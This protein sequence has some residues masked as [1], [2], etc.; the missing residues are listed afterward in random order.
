MRRR[1][2]RTKKNQVTVSLISF[3]DLIGGMIGALSLIIIS[4]SLSQVVPQIPSVSHP[5]Y[6]IFSIE[7]RIQQKKTQ[8]ESMHKMISEVENV[9]D[10]LRQANIHL[11]AL[12]KKVSQVTDR[13]INISEILEVRQAQDNE[14]KKL[15]TIRTQLHNELVKLTKTAEIKGNVIRDKIVVRFTGRGHDLDP[16][17]VECTNK[18]LIVMD[19]DSKDSISVR[20]ISKSDRLHVLLENV[21]KRDNGTV[22][23]LIRPDGIRAFN[24]ALTRT[25]HYKVRSGK[26]PVPGYGEIDLSHYKE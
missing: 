13:Q 2:R 10:D 21:K 25:Q 9:H 23:F 26:L 16:V 5:N 8:V 18:G 20:T 17:F 15:K 22:I 19:G 6:Q 4:I 7:D 24:R 14:I 12:R 11:E 3:I 1:W